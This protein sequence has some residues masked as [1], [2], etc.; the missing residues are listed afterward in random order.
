MKEPE[1]VPAAFSTEK[2]KEALYGKIA[3]QFPANIDSLNK[4]Y[5]RPKRKEVDLLDEAAES[6]EGYIGKINDFKTT[7]GYGW[8]KV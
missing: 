1:P 3:P 5:K 6:I 2:K 8:A 4:I 7:D